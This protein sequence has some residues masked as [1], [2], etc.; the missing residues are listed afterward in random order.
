MVREK[1]DDF[2]VQTMFSLFANEEKLSDRAV[3]DLME[4][5]GKELGR[6]DYP[7]VRTVN[8]YHAEYEGLP[9]AVKAGYKEFRWP[10]SMQ[11]LLPWE[12]SAAALELLDV[13]RKADPFI[14]YLEQLEEKGEETWQVPGMRWGRPSVRL[15]RWYWRVAQAVPDLPA[16]SWASEHPLHI[17]RIGVTFGFD[18]IGRYD[19]AVL[20][21]EWEAR[22]DTPHALRDG[23]EAYLSY[24]PWRCSER[25]A[26]YRAAVDASRITGLTLKD[27][28]SYENLSHGFPEWLLEK[29]QK[30]D[31]NGEA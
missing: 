12:A 11:V 31:T 24:A 30:E 1:L 23:I 2:W 6:D 14:R 8:K 3:A 20:L 26:E 13:R 22:T 18:I 5:L 29:F 16:L 28:Q 4:G 17:K 21:A 7:A 9:D 19:I 15:V 10:D 27:I 25:A